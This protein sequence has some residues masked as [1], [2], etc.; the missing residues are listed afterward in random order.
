MISFTFFLQKPV[1]IKYVSKIGLEI[2]Y[3]LV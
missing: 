2:L 1:F 3:D